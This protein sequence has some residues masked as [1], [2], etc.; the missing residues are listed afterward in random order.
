MSASA[1]PCGA[2]RAD[3]LDTG[4]QQLPRL[5][6]LGAHAA[7]AVR[8]VAE[9]Q[10]RLAALIARRDDARDRHG[11][12]RAQNEDG[13][14]LVEHAV[15]RL[16]FGHLGAREH[17]LVLQR[18][19]VHLAIAVTLEHAAKRVRDRA[20]LARLFGKHVAGAA[21]DWVD[22]GSAIEP[23]A[24]KANSE[25]PPGTPNHPSRARSAA[26][27]PCHRG[28]FASPVAAAVMPRSG[29]TSQIST[30][31]PTRTGVRM[32]S[33]RVRSYRYEHMFPIER[34][35]TLARS[36]AP[37]AAPRPLVPAARG[38]Q[39]GRLGG[40]PGPAHAPLQHPHRTRLRGR[41]AQRRA[42]EAP[43]PTQLCL[44]PVDRAPHRAQPRT[45][46]IEQTATRPANRTC[47]SAAPRTCQRSSR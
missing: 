35:S 2:G 11:H 45:R 38:R 34:T 46:R 21:W 3:E 10:R 44:S 40:R 4:L 16:S 25:Q 31:S 19:R 30:E 24:E 14:R 13:P 23:N 12:V 8:Q 32:R 6:A 22:H 5:A 41:Y 9:A 17:R 29:S 39:S 15:G 33:V 43:H 47:T 28:R 42:G 27:A 7:V 18:R 1:V 36:A 20:D 37:R 26:P